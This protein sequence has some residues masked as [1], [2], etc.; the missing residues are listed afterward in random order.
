MKPPANERLPMSQMTILYHA[1]Y[2]P[3]GQE[4]DLEVT[5]L[6]A[7]VAQGWVDNPAKFGRDIWNDTGSGENVAKTQQLYD[8]GFLPPVDDPTQPTPMQAEQMARMASENEE[9]RR[10]LESYKNLRQPLTL[11]Q[12][13]RML[14]EREADMA[15]DAAK[16]NAPPPRG[17]DDEES[18][19]SKQMKEQD[20]EAMLEQERQEQAAEE[21]AKDLAQQAGETAI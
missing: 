11:E 13:A 4:F 8:A 2:A 12:E 20:A 19:L 18:D 17:P 15:S 14:A 6:S 16:L 10:Q 7:L 3:D 9:L 1:S 21:E 5:A